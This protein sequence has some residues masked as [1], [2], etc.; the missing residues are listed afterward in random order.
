MRHKILKYS[1]FLGIILFTASGCKKLLEEQPRTGFTPSFFTT[2]DGIQ[3]AIS[4]IYSSFRGQWATQIW[5]QLFNSGT[6]ESLRGGSV[7]N[8]AVHWFVYNNPVIR[9]NTNNYEGFWNTLFI[10][11]NTA[12]GVLEYG[13]NANI[14]AATK[15]QLLAQAKFLRGF[16][17]FYLVT[18][19][20]QVPL[21]TTFSSS[22]SAADAPAPLADLYA[23]IIKDF[24][25]AAADLPN[26][27]APGTGKPATKSTALFLL[28]KT[29]LWRGWSTAA[30][31]NDNQQA[32]TI[33]KSIIDNKATYGLDLT[34]YFG[35]A[36]REGNEYGP[37]V[38]MVID[39]T[40]DLKFG[41]NSAVGAGATSFSENKSNFFWKPNY[42]TIPAN[43]PTNSGANVTVRD[44]RN[45]RPFVR[46]RPNT[47]YVMDVAFANRATDS[48][49]D[50]TF[51]TVWL[52]NSTA[53]SANGTT[54]AT[55]PRGT[56]INGVDTAIWM[57]DRVVTST[58]RAR[59]KGIIFEPDHIPASTVKYTAAYFPSVRKFDDST[60]GHMN[61]YS[62]RPYILFR[63]A[64][65]YLIAAE[66]ALRGGATLQ[67]AA[68]MINVLRTRAALK[69]G[70]TPAE[71][72]AA[73]VA[74]Q[75]TA[76]QV[77]LDFLLDERTRELYAED[78]R[79]WDLARTKKLVERVQ[80]HNAEAAAGVQPFN[81]LRPIPQSQI[82]LV[83]EGP[84]YPQNTGY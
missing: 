22:A 9:S 80:L 36:F 75:I 18:T 55:T 11:I 78:C 79:W 42:P 45:G 23:Q 50:G 58:E 26:T 73:V 39:H 8:G 47:K 14:P 38:L 30:Q 25:E 60:R 2:N 12:N 33:A 82:D 27:P 3:G 62:D 37:E 57:A 64:E 4:G 74:Q 77:T 51:Q 31:A 21:H 65:V 49:Y 69:I 61:D 71:Y 40:K 34:P 19:F 44:T 48:R 72:A 32:Y 17:Y 81:M 15:T 70:Q 6:D 68:N 41:Q 29:Y 59:F 13:A 83:T 53:E 52:S 16:C 20:G 54:G 56:L 1:L 67:D 10:D 46:L 66:A 28:S 5:T 24:T 7:D 63:F 43:W 35:N 84:K 76:A